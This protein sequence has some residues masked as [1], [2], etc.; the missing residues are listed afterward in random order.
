M[1]V[2][3]ILLII[4][5]FASLQAVAQKSEVPIPILPNGSITNQ[6]ADTMWVLHS[7]KQFKKITIALNNYKTCQKINNKQEQLIDSLSELNVQ[8]K[9]YIDSLKKEYNICMEEANNLYENSELLGELNTK[10]TKYTRIAIF[11]GAGTTVIAF[12]VGLFIGIK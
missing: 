4:I 6:T 5:F 1:R 9:D 12:L 2:K 8:R 11:T 3:T 7:T 10:Q